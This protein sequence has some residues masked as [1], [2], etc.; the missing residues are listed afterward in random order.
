MDGLNEWCLQQVGFP[1]RTFNM[2]LDKQ[3]VRHGDTYSNEKLYL[4]RFQPLY[5][6]YL[7]FFLS[8]L[9]LAVTL[10]ILFAM[11]EMFPDYTVA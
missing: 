8:R 5:L 4:G 1:G 7:S 9:Q 2:P 6:S 3:S 10:L 11:E